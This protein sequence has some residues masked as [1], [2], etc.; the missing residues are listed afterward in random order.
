ME[1]DPGQSW[2]TAVQA[3]YPLNLLQRI[4]TRVLM[5]QTWQILAM[6]VAALWVIFA[7]FLP[8]GD[9]LY[10][11]YQPFQHGCSTCGFV[12]PFAHWF[13]WLLDVLPAYPLTWPSWTLLSVI[14]WLVLVR[15]TKVNP[16][17]LMASFPLMG[18]LWLGQVDWLVAAGL[19]I[20]WLAK[21]PALRG[22]GILLALIKPQLSALAILMLLLQ[23]K[24][25]NIARILTLPAAGF[26]LSL[27]QFG[28]NWPV[29]WLLGA[30]AA[31]PL[32]QWRLAGMDTWLIGIFFIWLPLLFREPK[33]RLV[34]SLL[35]SSL[36]TPFFGVYSYVVFLVLFL[37]W[38]AVPLSYFWV[39]TSP[40]LGYN[41][42][43]LAWV[44]PLSLLAWLYVNREHLTKSLEIA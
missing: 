21:H 30:S 29:Q 1:K 13:L 16:L 15:W 27:W 20:F 33:Q 7:F 17:L 2:K 41:A 3:W 8:G 42:M 31:V 36:A 26:L 40:W 37:P 10:R 14:A 11:Y 6:E 23:E 34:A 32:H 19:V 44:L 18:Q 43:R 28:L 12:P 35:V 5:P 25:A 9:D 4:K 24:P 39:I 22:A 38:W